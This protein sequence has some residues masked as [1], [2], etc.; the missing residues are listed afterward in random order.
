MQ[1]ESTARAAIAALP[2]AFLLHVSE[3]WL[4]GPGLVAWVRDV[5]GSSLNPA[6]LLAMNCVALS[7]MSL[8]AFASLRRPHWTWTSVIAASALMFNALFHAFASFWFSEYSPG[9][10]TGVA[11]FIPIGMLILLHAARVLSTLTF[12]GAVLAG[13]SI[14]TFILIGTLGMGSD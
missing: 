14:H 6:R 4:A 9:T 8:A 11:L 13:V 1:N 10:W 7:L 5:F 12:T 2:V 3:E